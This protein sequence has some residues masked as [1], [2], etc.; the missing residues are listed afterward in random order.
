MN[1]EQ[2]DRLHELAVRTDN[3]VL[4][5]CLDIHRAYPDENDWAVDTISQLAEAYRQ[6]KELALE[7]AMLMPPSARLGTKRLST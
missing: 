2:I 4:K 5:A 3:A 7:Q 1:R 6:M